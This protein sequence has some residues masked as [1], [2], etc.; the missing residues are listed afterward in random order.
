M[1]RLYRVILRE[2]AFITLAKL[3]KYIN[4]QGNE[5][6]LPEDDTI[7]TKHVGA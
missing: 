7:E 5:C 4:W 1:F 6:E 2:R 3:H